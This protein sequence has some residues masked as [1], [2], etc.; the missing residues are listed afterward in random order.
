MLQIHNVVFK[1]ALA[2]LSLNQSEDKKTYFFAYKLV[3]EVWT[4]HICLNKVWHLCD[5]S[6][7]TL[8]FQINQSKSLLLPDTA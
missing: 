2:T 1:L 4:C 7:I 3:T 8:E 5:Q 6:A